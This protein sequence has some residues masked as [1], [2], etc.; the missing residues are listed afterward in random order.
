MWTIPGLSLGLH[1][2]KPVTNH[3]RYGTANEV[4]SMYKYNDLNLRRSAYLNPDVVFWSTCKFWDSNLK[5]AT[6]IF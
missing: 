1:N 2:E 4:T 5:E 3:L 6:A